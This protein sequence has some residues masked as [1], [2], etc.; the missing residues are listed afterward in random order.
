LGGN[1]RPWGQEGRCGGAETRDAGIDRPALCS[2][3]GKGPPEGWVGGPTF[4]SPG[5]WRRMLSFKEV[6]LGSAT[7]SLG[8]GQLRGF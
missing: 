3:L 6:R 2:V 8:E 1:D 5:I 4:S 7:V